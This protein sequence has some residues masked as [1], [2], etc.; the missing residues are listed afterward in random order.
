VSELSPTRLSI[1]ILGV[2]LTLATYFHG[3]DSLHIPKNGD[4]YVY[5]HILRLTADSGA[6]LPLQSEL[7]GMRNT[8]P[9]LIYWQGIASTNWATDWEHWRL[10]WPSVI[11]T[12][13]TGLMIFL[14]ARKLVSLRTG[15][16]AF[17]SFMAFVT[18]YRY[19]RPFLTDP[20]LV[21]W[22]TLPSLALL[23]WRE[24]LFESKLLFPVLAGLAFGMGFLAKS[25]MLLVPVGLTMA[26]WYWR[27]RDYAIAPFIIRDSWKL[28]LMSV[29]AL[30]IFSLWFILDPDPKAILDEFVYKENVGKVAQD[31]YWLKLLWGGS[32]IWSQAIGLLSNTGLL[33]VPA[34]V[35]IYLAFRQRNAQSSEERM[36]WIW[37]AVYF[38]IFSLPTQRSARYLI[39][40]MPAFAILLSLYWDR[41][42]RWAF[43]ISLGLAALFVLGIGFFS[44]R[45]ESYLGVE[46]I[47]PF[48]VWAVLALALGGI[49]FALFRSD[50]TRDLT[51][52]ALILVYFCLSGF[53]YPFDHASGSF[54]TETQQKARGNTVWV[55]YNFRAKYER[56]RFLLPGSD[57]RGYYTHDKTPDA[58]LM[59]QHEYV[60][61]RHR[62][63]EPLDT[64]HCETLG[65]RLEV[66]SRHNSKEIREILLEN[67]MDHLFVREHLLHCPR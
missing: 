47:Y 60:V 63:D 8:K 24:Q 64:L 20:P 39:P 33:L 34:A 49:V 30:A 35:M 9:P 1:Y 67:R 53:F 18:T 12:L 50:W 17:L 57:I 4:E 15:F 27:E 25:F 61:I 48:Y 7:E 26:W 13:L 6:M 23:Y 52:I 66:R 45:L 38:V 11:Y 44:L 51:P 54:P 28:A 10:R 43:R 42:P 37:V 3:L 36:L 62:A 59:R 46:S 14:F 19:G 65:T 5:A 21:F 32:S 29:I 41:I 2:A 58:E 31:N 22:L 56:Y 16:I 55:P 40:V